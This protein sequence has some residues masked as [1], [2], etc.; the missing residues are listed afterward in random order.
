MPYPLPQ[1]RPYRA[2]PSVAPLLA[3]VVG[4]EG[5]PPP[6]SFAWLGYC[7]ASFLLSASYHWVGYLLLSFPTHSYLWLSMAI[8]SHPVAITTISTITTTS[9]YR[10]PV[11]S[12][13]MLSHCSLTP[14]L[15]SLNPALLVPCY[16]WVLFRLQ[17]SLLPCS[18]P[19]GFQVFFYLN[20]RLHLL[21]D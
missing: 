13:A 4:G 9:Y 16:L 11:H 6:D 17:A 12:L 18:P 8:Y 14:A 19:R 21:I 15:H 10:R 3:A 7:T 1:V 5:G 2:S 20:R